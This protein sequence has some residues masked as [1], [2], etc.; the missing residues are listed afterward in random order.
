MSGAPPFRQR[1][2]TVLM[3]DLR[4]FTSFSESQPAAVVLE[5]LNNFVIEM[6]RVIVRHDGMIDKFMGD[7]IMALFG[8][9]S[10]GH[11]DVSRAVSCAVQM[12][13]AMMALNAR[14]KESGT[15][16]VYMGIGVNT[17]PVIA[18]TF[19][20]ELYSVFTVVGDTVNL[21]SRIEAVSLRGQVLI[22]D[23]TYER[24]RDYVTAGGPMTVYVKGKAQAIGFREVLG[25]PSLGLTVPRQELRRSPRVQAKLPFSYRAVASDLVGQQHQAST[26][27]IS[28]HGLL[29]QMP[30][31]VAEHSEISLDLPLPVID[32]VAKGV[33]A[34]VVKAT[35]RDGAN[36]A[37]IE[38]TAIGDADAAAV[39]RFVQM[40]V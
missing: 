23:G 38:F 12:Q 3:G 35:V 8:A 17:G 26:L 29:A 9:E 7:S 28:Y 15:P 1:E 32:H 4:G 27:D 33:Y 39:R 34:R 10:A 36:L 11:D 24:C 5:I 22:S 25:I 19:G 40:L 16:P 13:V 20:S 6:S 18:G 2:V 30:T 21:A 31:R 37:A 14:H